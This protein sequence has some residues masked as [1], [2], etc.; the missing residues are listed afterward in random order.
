MSERGRGVRNEIIRNIAGIVGMRMKRVGEE[1]ASLQ[2][3]QNG[4]GTKLGPN[5]PFKLA[6]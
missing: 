5:N 6:S 4:A 3:A 1:E 2:P